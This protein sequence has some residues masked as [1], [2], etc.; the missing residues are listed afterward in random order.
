MFKS[1][2]RKWNDFQFDSM[3]QQRVSTTRQML[4]KYG[5]PTDS[6]IHSICQMYAKEIVLKNL[7]KEDENQISY[8]TEKVKK[9]RIEIQVMFQTDGYSEDFS[10]A[11]SH[12]CVGW[13]MDAYKN[14]KTK[15]NI[16][17]NCLLKKHTQ[18]AGL[19]T[20]SMLLPNSDNKCDSHGLA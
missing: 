17:L 14:G 3:I 18:Y 9:A 10:Y 6:E 4:A 2:S 7:G 8:L 1:L 15:N 16:T 13:D 19:L 20:E 11:L 12:V 5:P